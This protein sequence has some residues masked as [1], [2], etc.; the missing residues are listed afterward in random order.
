MAFLTGPRGGRRKGTLAAALL[1]TTVLAGG[2]FAWAESDNSNPQTAPATAPLGLAPV[3]NQTG[4]ADLAAKVGPAVVNIATTQGVDQTAEEGAP[5]LRGQMP[6]FPPGSPFGEMFRHYFNGQ[7]QGHSGAPAHAL[8]SGFI[9]DPAGYVVTNNHVVE[10]ANDV[11][12]T[13]TDGQ[14]Y[15]AKV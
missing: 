15:T 4:F 1:A 10:H 5:N 3:V 14:T 12:V 9:V 7:G 2:G 11:K 13:L 6:N 8:G